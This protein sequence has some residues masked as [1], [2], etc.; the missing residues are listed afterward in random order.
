MNVGGRLFV[1][2][3]FLIQQE[4]IAQNLCENREKP[5][6]ECN[7]KCHLKKELAKEEKKEKKDAK[8]NYKEQITYYICAIE[9][10]IELN[11]DFFEKNEHVN[12]AVQS[13]KVGY[14]DPIFH[15]PTLL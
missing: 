10:K 14:V 2:V 8:L 9:E 5:E 6:M 3:N 1:Y 12:P 15:P 13:N 7:G 4:Y 11:Q